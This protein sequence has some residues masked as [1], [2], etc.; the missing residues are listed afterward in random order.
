MQPK[1]IQQHQADTA[2]AEGKISNITVIRREKKEW[3]FTFEVPHPITGKPELFAIETQKGEL[4]TWVDP[5]NLI[6]FLRDKYGV[7]EAKLIFC[8][9]SNGNNE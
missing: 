3:Y 1:T 9:E 7:E 8:E 2:S 6:E 4:R 5:R